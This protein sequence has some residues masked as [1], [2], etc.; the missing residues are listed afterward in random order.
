MDEEWRD[1]QCEWVHWSGH[2]TSTRDEYE[3]VMGPATKDHTYPGRD[4][5]NDGDDIE[6]FRADDEIVVAA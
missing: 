1:R 6:R 5:N 3:Y 4:I 2:R